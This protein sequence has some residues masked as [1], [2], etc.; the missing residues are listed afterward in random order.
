MPAWRIVRTLLLLTPSFVLLGAGAWFVLKQFS[1]VPDLQSSDRG[2][3]VVVVVFDQMRGDYLKRW[4]AMFDSNGF[5]RIKKDG[6]W[7]SDA[8]LP[9]A[10]SSTGPGHASIS[11]GVPPS[12]HGI[13]ENEW[14]DR[15][16]SKK[17]Y[18]ASG[19]RPYDRVPPNPN[20]GSRTKDGGGLAPDRLL[21]STVGDALTESKQGRVFSLALKDRAAVLMGG[22]SPTGCYCFDTATGQFHTSS[23]YR[24]KAHPWVEAF[25]SSNGSDKWFQKDWTRLGDETLYNKLAGPD[26]VVGESGGPGGPGRVFPHKFTPEPTPGGRYYASLEATPFGNELLWDFA[27]TAIEAEKLGQGDTP[28]LLFLGFSANDVIGHANGPDSHEVLDATLRS[29][30]LIGEMI[31]YLEAKVGAGRFTIIITADHGV[32]PLPEVAVKTHPDAERFSPGEAYGPLGAVLDQKFGQADVAAG[33]WVEV[34]DFPWVYLNQRLI[35]SQGI[36]PQTVDEAATQWCANHPSIA[37]TAFSRTELAGPPLMDPLGRSVQLAFHPDRCGD[38]FVVN[39]PYTLQT[40]KFSTGTSHGTPH[41]YDTHVPVL[42][43]GLNIPMTGEQEGLASSLIVAPLIC[44]ALG[45]E[46]PAGLSEKLP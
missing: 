18:C 10:C 24:E 4:S 1:G 14:Y 38:V 33:K 7:Y 16:R 28:D 39:K 2:R 23:Y 43:Y 45:I 17:V 12:I 3:L 34:L 31:Q 9:Y 29:D 13:I 32:C 37:Q 40:G 46:P 35:R 44:K 5:E 25:N 22:K 26:D 27:K 15:A 20:A 8:H 36:V 19:D 41:A 11:T 21:V 6:V 30:R 42:A